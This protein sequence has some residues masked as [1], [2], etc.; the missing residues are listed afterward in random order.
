[1]RN[2]ENRRWETRYLIWRW[3]YDCAAQI[4]HRRFLRSVERMSKSFAEAAETTQRA[5]EAMA[6]FAAASTSVGTSDSE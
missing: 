3:G 1:M 6:S 2:L 5:A 4:I